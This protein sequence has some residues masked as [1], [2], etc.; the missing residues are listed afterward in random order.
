MQ[1]D[2]KAIEAAATTYGEERDCDVLFQCGPLNAR[3]YDRLRSSLADGKRSNVLLVLVTRGGDAHDAF[4]IGRFLQRE[5]EKVN[6][7]LPGL[8]KSAGTLLAVAGHNLIMGDDGELG[9]IDIQQMRQDDLW[10]RAS[11]LIESSALESLG[12]VTWDLFEKIVTEIKDM[13]YGRITFKTAAE[14]AAPI[15]TGVLSPISS[16][17]D[18]LKV[19]ETSRAL[20]IA[21][22]Y[23]I[24]LNRS[25]RNLHD[26][27]VTR[28]STGYPDHAFIIDR[29][30]AKT[31]FRNI[32]APGESLR[33]LSN[34][35]Q[36]C[37]AEI[38]ASILL[39]RPE[40]PS[41]PID[42]E[43][44]NEVD[45]EAD[46]ITG[47]EDGTARSN[48]EVARAAKDPAGNTEDRVPA[49]GG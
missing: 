21:A 23:A 29:E 43:K 2:H 25:S 9:P 12:Q 11:G 37:D 20:Q 19:G 14:A 4:R 26:M 18:P 42:E 13:S 35:L 47:T 41:E 10:E 48:G 44:N 27:A 7:L 17:I 6:V 15:V 8:C 38:S 36:A 39:N 31:L 16:Q 5:Y 33:K 3:A 49:T 30:E 22:N 46:G 32:S 40:T 24:R 28:L 45:V 1:I 34:A